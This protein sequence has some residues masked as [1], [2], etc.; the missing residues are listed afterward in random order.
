MSDPRRILV[1][2]DN[3]ASRYAMARMLAREGYTVDQAATG[4][5]ALERAGGPQ[6]PD[7]VVLDVQLPGISGIDVCR[8]LKSEPVAL[9]VMVL[10]TSAA[11]TR[12]QD[13]AYGLDNG[14]DGYLVQPID[15]IELLATVRSLLRIREME[16]KLLRSNHELE[17]FAHAAA[18]DLREPLRM[19]ANYVQ[20]I[21]RR[22]GEGFDE[23]GRS[24][25]GFVSD[26]TV[27]MARLIDMLLAFAS[28]DRGALKRADV[29]A[30]DLVKDAMDNVE[31]PL[32]ES[33]G[34][35][36]HGDLPRIAVDRAQIT[37]VFQNLMANAIKFRREVAPE[38]VISARDRGDDWL[39]AIADNG[40]GIKPEHREKAFGLF[41]RL[42]ADTSIKGTGLGL[43]LCRKIVERHGGR[44]WLES[45]FGRGSTFFFTMPKAAATIAGDKD[46]AV[47]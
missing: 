29:A 41:Q 18:H 32:A 38:V 13:R 17:L 43:A 30:V 35:V 2:D 45:E 4:E 34:R 26:G 16:E 31:V 44:I 33:G 28:V 3:E 42:H 14:A 37:Q 12:S 24:W 40:I 21:A 9:S 11:M 39:F 27:R 15:P 10:Q 47:A 19:I 22:Y 6:R 8:R 25:F 23:K 20:L 36:E 46:D 5:E 7:L 1:V